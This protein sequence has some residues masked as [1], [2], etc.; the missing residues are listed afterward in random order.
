MT[1]PDLLADA[2]QDLCDTV[3]KTKHLEYGRSE[4]TASDGSK[5]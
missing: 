5:A 3:K 4:R 1:G 2:L